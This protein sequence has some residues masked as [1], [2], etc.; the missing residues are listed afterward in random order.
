[1]D[2]RDTHSDDEKASP[3]APAAGAS[4]RDITG[5]VPECGGAPRGAVGA[6]AAYRLYRRRFVGV[7]GIVGV[8]L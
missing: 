6:P 2:S 8:G 4:P 7:V 1:M 3:V 5:A